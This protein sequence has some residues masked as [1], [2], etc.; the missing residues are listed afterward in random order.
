MGFG[1]SGAL[2]SV[3]VEAGGYSIKGWE[4]VFYVFGLLGILLFPAF[5]W[6]VYDC[7]EA[8]PY[9]TA[10]EVA[11]IKDG[12]CL[13]AL[14]PFR[15]HLNNTILYTSGNVFYDPLLLE[16]SCADRDSV[17]EETDIAPLLSSARDSD[18]RRRCSSSSSHSRYIQ[19]II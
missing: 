13:R 16:P 15:S 8:H 11:I 12:N 1:L 5:Y 14:I 10:E 18:I 3:D 19:I 4:L 6:R 7:P 9:C 17:I 2:V